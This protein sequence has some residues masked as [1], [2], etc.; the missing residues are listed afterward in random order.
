MLQ[1]KRRAESRQRP[2]NHDDIKWEDVVS[3]NLQ[4]PN[5]WVE[6]S[7][8]QRNLKDARKKLQM[9]EKELTELA[10]DP[11]SIPLVDFELKIQE[12]E[13]ART[14]MIMQAREVMQVC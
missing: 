11:K 9:L 6:L 5:Y 12:L 1:K 7:E 4:V 14:V 10:T 3:Y 8:S 13:H 2:Q